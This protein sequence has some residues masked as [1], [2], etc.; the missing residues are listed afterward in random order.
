MLNTKY[1]N[2]TQEERVAKLVSE[3]ALL[4]KEGAVQDSIVDVNYNTARKI[5]KEVENFYYE[6]ITRRMTAEAA[7]EQAKA[8]VDKIA[9]DYELGK[10][11][12]DNENQKNLREWIYGGINQISEIIGSLSKFK[13]A[14]ALLK[15][16]EKAI[17]EPNK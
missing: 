13:Q 9:K 1:L 17:K 8:M 2:E 4:Q 3:I 10:G 12:L 6:M 16:L 11:H 15:R 7:K 5:Q 14:E